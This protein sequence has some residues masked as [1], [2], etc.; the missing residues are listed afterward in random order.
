MQVGLRKRELRFGL[1]ELLVQIGGLDHS[2]LLACLDVRADIRLPAFQVSVGSGENRRFEPGPDFRRQH[3][4]V[5]ISSW[6][7]GNNR[8]SRDCQLAGVSRGRTALTPAWQKAQQESRDDSDRSDGYDYQ[9]T[10]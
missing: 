9:H 8:H 4:T 5:T 6:R 10:A 7:R 2:K 3:Q 1:F